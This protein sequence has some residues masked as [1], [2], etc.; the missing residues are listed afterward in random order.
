MNDYLKPPFELLSDTG[1]FDPAVAETSWTLPSSW[2]YAPQ[3]YRL[4]QQRIF[5]KTWCY[6]CHQS[7]LTSTGDEYYG[8]VE[9]QPVTIRRL[10]TEGLQALH[11]LSAAALAVEVF[12]GFVFVN[13]DADAVSL[14]QQCGKFVDDIQRCCPRIDELRPRRRIERVVGV[15]WKTL[16]DNNHECY[17]CAAN[18]KSLMKLVDYRNQ[19]RWSDDGITFSHEVKR[20]QLDNP[21]Y[22]LD[23]ARIEQDSLFGYIWPTLIPL[24]FPG[25]ASAVLFQVIPTGPESSIARHDFYFS[26]ATLSSQEL[27][28]I[29]YID[30]ELVPEDVALCEAVQR[31][32]HS[33][34]Y[35]QG[36]LVVDR[37]HPEY[38]EH[39]VH[40]FQQM[41]YRALVEQS[42]A[43]LS[44]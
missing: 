27:S 7:E 29:D 25:S 28:F 20:R 24:W 21:A 44:G 35:R 4:E 22:R 26:D 11:S 23:P 43:T 9:N 36:K 14:A 40:F 32:L 5:A 18:H 37:A 3:I 39:H 12:A 13:L 42:P 2:Y 19:A 8:R 6:Q 31:G 30:R 10:P 38:S 1:R 15:N 16:I 34:G 33:R 41:V 17:H